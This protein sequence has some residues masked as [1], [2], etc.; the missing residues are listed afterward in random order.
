MQ[1]YVAREHGDERP[2]VQVMLS[3]DRRH[4][5]YGY[6]RIGALLPREDLERTGSA[7]RRA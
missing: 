5:R 7:L 1:R 6:R 3:L 4:P 2:L